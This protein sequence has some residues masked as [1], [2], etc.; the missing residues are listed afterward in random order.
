MKV[1]AKAYII[2]ANMGYGHQRAAYALKG[3]VQDRI[4]TAN[5]DP[6]VPDSDNA[7]WERARIF[8]ETVTRLKEVPVVGRFTFDIYDKLQHISPFFPFRDLSRPT[9]SVRRL[10]RLIKAKGFGRS[11]VEYV[12][13]SQLPVITTHFIPALVFNYH[14]RE[15][16]C[17]VT[18]T[19]IH[20]VWASRY[21]RKGCITY[22]SPCR[23]ASLRLRAYGV[24]HHRIIETG[25]PLPKENIG[26][27]RSILHRD[28]VARLVNLDPNGVFFENYRGVIREKL[29]AD[30]SAP[31]TSFND[32]KR[33]ATHPLTITY[34]IG[35]A[36]AQGDIVLRMIKALERRLR[37]E[38]IKIN[39]AVG[40]K[41]EVKEWLERE[42]ERIGLDNHVGRG[43]TILY[44]D[45]YE[46]YYAAVNRALRATDILWSKPS[47]VS[48]YTGL[49]L[50]IVMAPYIGAHEKYNRDWL[51]HL[52]SGYI[53]EDPDQADAWLTYWLEDGRLARAALQGYLYA[54]CM[55]T[56]NIEKLIQERPRPA[57][58]RAG[59]R[60]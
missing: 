27:R 10:R 12:G 45:I 28:L 52:G 42:V 38:R 40:T 31:P 37:E 21:P 30:D 15:V 6:I 51:S 50:P 47:E 59:T 57:A 43:I 35:G 54:P 22:L 4:I 19:D 34:A 26:E 2:S 39:I 25:F 46:E 33:H 53:Q 49:G 36:G 23:H 41:P 3:L 14:G 48:F 13:D 9:Y 24:P 58:V 29:F 55:G 16:Y 17:V 56:Y 44:G 11:L 7:L 8:Y 20:R 32:L 5:N 18:D 1:T 60:A